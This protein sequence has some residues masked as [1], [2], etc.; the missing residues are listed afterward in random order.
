MSVKFT[1]AP[2][3][4]YDGGRFRVYGNRIEIDR[5]GFFGGVKGVDVVYYGD[6]TSV[7]ASRK[8]RVIARTGWKTNI[9]DFKNRSR[10][11]KCW[12]SSTPTSSD[13]IRLSVACLSYAT[14]KSS[15][16]QEG[17]RG[18]PLLCVLLTGLSGCG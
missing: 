8:Q 13:A 4:L 17:R 15:E 11:R 6:I 12:T 3:A 18:K 16:S 10:S 1:P 5:L 7:Q 2:D 14:L 9:L